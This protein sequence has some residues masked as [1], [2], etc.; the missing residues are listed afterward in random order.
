VV[1]ANERSFELYGIRRERLVGL[2][3][4]AL[5]ASA[6]SESAALDFNRV[7]RDGA[8]RIETIHVDA[9]GREFPVEVSCHPVRA[10]GLDYVLWIIRDNS[11]RK[12]AEADLLESNRRLRKIIER[13]PFGMILAKDDG[14][15]AEFINDA[16]EAITGYGISEAG[17]FQQALTHL[18]SD[19]DQRDQVRLGV[20]EMVAEAKRTGRP[21]HKHLDRITH[22]D[23][24]PRYVEIQ[25]VDL[26]TI[27]IWT[28]NDVTKMIEAEQRVVRLSMLKDALGALNR[29]IVRV[30]SESEIW[31]VACRVIVERAG[32]VGAWVGLI[33]IDGERVRYVTAT[34]A[35]AEHYREMLGDSIGDVMSADELA[36][37]AVTERSTVISRDFQN[38]KR[39]TRWHELAKQY[40]V[41]SAAFVPVLGK[42]TA[43]G[44]LAIYL[45]ETALLDDE[46]V[47]LFEEM[48]GD[49]SF[50]FDAIHAEQARQ[51][52]ESE[53]H[54]SEARFRSIIEQS[55]SGI[56]IIDK[57]QRF[58]Y[59]NPRMAEIFGYASNEEIANMPI[60]NLV[61]PE[62]RSLVTES[63]R[64]RLEG[65]AQSARYVFSGLRKDGTSIMV[66]VHGTVGTY[67]GKPVIIGTLQDVTE[68]ERAE[69]K[70][71]EY[72]K[73]L[74]RTTHSTIEIISTMGELRDPYTQGHERRVGEIAAAIGAEMGL[75]EET[76]EGLRVAGHLHDVGK[77]SVPAEILS[78]PGKLTKL[79][80]DLVKTHA[81]KGYEILKNYEFPW[82][83]A[84]VTLQH[85][86]RMDGSGYPQG[87]KGDEIKL[88]ARIL[89]VADTVE[90]MSSHRPYR[91][92]LGLERALA[93]VEKDSG[94]L[95]DPQVVSACLR[96]F[97]DKGYRVSD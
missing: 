21:S 31:E 62:N 94:R 70:M 85:H 96:L 41:T 93:E 72:V 82:P 33:G 48:A 32:G 54:E 39:T 25:F 42:E 91:P 6:V 4:T 46:M 8:A 3:V 23:G 51:R 73:T 38:D 79:E 87:L 7:M 53:L 24:S 37:T 63:L 28:F 15:T 22:R 69:E 47:S 40:G 74:E 64:E 59:V 52:T 80:Y 9:Q 35:V 84:Q 26:D 44:V 76:L 50:A 75:D 49:L 11:E 10:D 89:G 83:V 2:S 77:I 95:F 57:R 92:G 18:T 43:I 78:K 30:K 45:D 20:N 71:Q 27:G 14:K 13:L 90:A 34:G 86:E 56:Y 81:R 88:E 19:L 36:C 61:A 58:I 97:R 68:V 29:T 60:V 65:N 12:R 17:T 5:S 67:R 16:F 1:E 66:G 55:I